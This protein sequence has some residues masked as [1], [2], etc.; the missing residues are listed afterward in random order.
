M[1]SKESLYVRG[2]VAQKERKLHGPVVQCEH[3]S[4]IPDSVLLDGELTGEARC[5]YAYLAGCIW[6]GTTTSVGMRL[7]ATK[8]NFHQ[9]TVRKAILLLA[10]RKHLTICGSGKRRRLYHL[11]S[12]VFTVEQRK[13]DSGEVKAEK[14]VS[15]PNKRLAT[16]RKSA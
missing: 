10:D 1:T 6:E 7:I 3:F 13:L 12:D 4:R 15:Y 9:Q 8:L 11:H 5:V 2:P 14:I 16:T